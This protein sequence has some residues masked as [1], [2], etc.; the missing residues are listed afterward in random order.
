MSKPKQILLIGEYY[1][2]IVDWLKNDAKP[3]GVPAIYNFYNYLGN[4]DA[5]QFSSI[6]YNP[7]INK[8]ISFPNGST[9][10]LKK[11][12]FP[13][14][15][16]WK[17]I[18]FLKLY[19]WGK[20][21]IKKNNYD[22]VYGFSTFSTVAHFLGKKSNIKS[23][24]RIL[25]TILTKDFTR[26]NF[27]K[28]YTRYFFDVLA[29]KYPCDYVITTMDGSGYDKVF[30]HFN[31]NMKIHLLANGM[32]EKMRSRLL[33][34]ENVK[35]ITREEPI[36]LCYV[37]RLEEYK[38]VDRGLYLVKELIDKHGLTNIRFTILGAGSKEQ[39]LKELSNQLGLTKYVEFLPAIA[40][41]ELPNFLATQHVGMFF[42]QGGSIGNILWETGM[43]GRLVLTIDNGDT[44]VVFKD[45]LNCLI[46]AED[47]DFISN[48]ADKFA[49][50]LDEDISK[51]TTSARNT[52]SGYVGTWEDRFDRELDI[53]FPPREG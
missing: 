43:S 51:I 12:Y 30:P 42:Y 20:N 38:R 16:L 19:F 50:I 45:V 1:A 4:S 9:I 18:V 46:A 35:K 40:H 39:I 13:G 41:E 17:A 14:Y 6:I 28:I 36:H 31:K 34:I 44:G 26:G 47:D 23:A 8:T 29:M 7:E 32:E 5:V 24:G 37:A 3:Q 21:K 2:P 53:I 48:M 15:Y 33:A 11:F 22:L 27:F 49:G 25:G 52:V 10:E